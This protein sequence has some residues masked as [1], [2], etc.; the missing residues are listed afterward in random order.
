MKKFYFIKRFWLKI[1]KEGNMKAF[2]WSFFLAAVQ[3]PIIGVDLLFHHWLLVDM[4]GNQLVDRLTLRIGFPQQPSSLRGPP[5]AGPA[6]QPFSGPV[7]PLHKFTSLF[8]SPGVFF[9]WGLYRGLPASSHQLLH[10]YTSLYA[11]QASPQGRQPL[12]PPAA[13]WEVSQVS[14]V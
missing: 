12:Q 9:N 4:A 2:S 1:A 5:A 10:G 14:H 3:F 8:P 11:A 7:E 6:L 13:C